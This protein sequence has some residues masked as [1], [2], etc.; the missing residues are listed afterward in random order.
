MH[1]SE[2]LTR[3]AEIVAGDRERTHGSKEHNF[4]AIAA[5]WNGYFAARRVWKG[6]APLTGEDVAALMVTFKV[7]RSL[8]GAHNPDDWLDMAGYAAIGGQLADA[9]HTKEDAACGP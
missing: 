7:A 9:R 4:A 2:I 3:A 6:D 1:A 8:G 5:L